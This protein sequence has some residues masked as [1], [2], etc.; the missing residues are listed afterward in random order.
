VVA[1]GDTY[2]LEP[3][4]VESVAREYWTGVGLTTYVAEEG[5]EI[6]GTYALKA[7]QRGLGSH[8]ANAGDMVRP[9]KFGKGIGGRLCE[10]S[11][12]EAR[13]VG[14]EAMQ[15]NAVVSTNHR[16]IALWRRMEFMIVG[17]I[18]K[19]TLIK[20]CTFA[21]DLLSWREARG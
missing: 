3:G 4:V 2:S 19:E 14:F 7:N 20:S 1:S 5:G 9:G 16:A 18:P 17:T 21:G 10:H 8:V 13:A 6:V 15:F 12:T 11:L